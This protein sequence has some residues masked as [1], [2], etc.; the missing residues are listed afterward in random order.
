MKK[1]LL[2][3][4][5]VL[6]LGASLF[7]GCS[8]KNEGGDTIKLGVIGPLTGPVATYGQS[9]KN[10]IAL[11]E[12]E[13]NA[14]GGINGKKVSISYQ[15]DQADQSAAINAFN[16]LVDDEKVCAILG[17]VT[18]G[19]T[20]AIASKATQAKIPLLTPTAT[21]PSITKVGGEFVFRG[22]YVDSFQGEGAAKYAAKD[23]GKK[24][25]AVLYN[26]S[27][28][29]SKGIAEAFK[30]EFEANGGKVVEFSTYN[31]DDKDFNAQLTKI[32]AANPDIIILP[33]YY[34]KVALIAKQ[35]RALGITAQFLGSDG[36][37]SSDFYKIGGDAVVGGLFIN[38]Y[39][40]ADTAKEVQDFV[41]AY[42]KE[43]NSEPDALAALGYDGAKTMFQALE[44]AKST[45]GDKIR[46]ALA[47]V[48]YKGVTGNITFGDDR[49]AIKGAVILKVD[50][51]KTSVVSRVKP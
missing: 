45:D 9:V 48:N 34:D 26:V 37:D 1:R 22:C 12:K 43:Y 28:D 50:G 3:G 15:D 2:V 31:K 41:T 30:K 7:Y 17:G 5:I 29:Y 21:E 38:H 10:G 8:K 27:S 44:N 39:S 24:N 6:A 23:L 16:K 42:K 18:S 40:P 47:K 13:V 46:E 51:A 19:S 35:A 49:T 25:A 32:K 11:A 4:A 14:A 33:D 36:W 20:L